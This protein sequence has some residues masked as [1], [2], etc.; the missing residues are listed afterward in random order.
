MPIEDCQQFD[1]N[2]IRLERVIVRSVCW[3]V[4]DGNPHPGPGMTSSRKPRGGNVH[5]AIF[6]FYGKGFRLFFEMRVERDA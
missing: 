2:A 6:P 1:A 3:R 4:A 5:R